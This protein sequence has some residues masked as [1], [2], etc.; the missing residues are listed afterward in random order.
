MTRKRIV[1]SVDVERDISRYVEE[2][3]VGVEEGIRPLLEMLDDLEIRSNFF[4]T[5]DIC[6]K[7]PDLV[8]DMSSGGH[9]VGCHGLEHR[10]QYYSSKTKEW[11]EQ[12]ISK[13]K[14]EI[15]K[16]VNKAPKI[17]RAP[18][19]SV[20]SDTLQ[21]LQSLNFEMDSSILPGRLV[22][23]WRLFTL[24]DFRKAP[25]EPYM[26]SK[27]DITV[28]G[29]SG[30][31]EI[32]ITE[33]PLFEG[34]PIGSGYLNYFGEEKFHKAVNA[35]EQSYVLLLFHPWELVDLG[36]HFPRLPD[37][38]TRACKKD[39][40]GVKARLRELQSSYQFCLLEDIAADFLSE[41]S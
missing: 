35:V 17:F 28:P 40:R 25:R 22:K 2:S 27:E 14:R 8:S 12:D 24:L 32:P 5:G 6:R 1:L 20:N 38:V 29:E 3:Y 9:S 41:D 7:Y 4:V 37:W 10:V 16:V 23:K 39:F 19:F 21:V 36:R 31:V 26:P 33:N 13:A 18:N 30:I 15:Q 11:Q 34:I